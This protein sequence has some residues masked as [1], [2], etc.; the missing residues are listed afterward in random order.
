MMKK[1]NALELRQS[2]SKIIE[3][4]EKTGQ[5]ILLEKGRKPA[6]VLI[7]LEDFQKRFFEIDADEKR[8]QIVEKIRNMA[9]KSGIK[10]SS[11]EIIRKFRE[12]A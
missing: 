9:R 10:E 6:A 8:K 7:T 5:P 3:T 2:L 4:L 11:E 12:G 1:V